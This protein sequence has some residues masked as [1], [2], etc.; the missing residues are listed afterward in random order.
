MM[1]SAHEPPMQS[2]WQHCESREHAPPL[3][4]QLLHAPKSHM[5]DAHCE[6][7]EHAMPFGLREHAPFA[8]SPVQQSESAAHCSA[9]RLHAVH[10]PP[11]HIPEQH[12]ESMEHWPPPGRQETQEPVS[13]LHA[14]LQQFELRMHSAPGAEQEHCPAS[15]IPEQHA[16]PVEHACEMSRH[17]EQRPERLQMPL[18]HSLAPEHCELSGLLHAP[19]M[20]S[21]VQHWELVL[22]CAPPG[23]QLAHKPESHEPE[24]HCRPDMHAFPSPLHCRQEPSEQ[25]RPAEHSES[26]WQLAPS[27]P[28][29]TPESHEPPQHCESDAHLFG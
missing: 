29:H 1:H 28:L 9:A 18:W 5:S 22:H 24:Q 16:E 23:T 8:Q 2:D 6:S 7:E 13:A 10:M 3:P 26:A 11:W 12:C 14:L 25:S 27:N 21:P 19:A 17:G 4:R 20:Q 15:H